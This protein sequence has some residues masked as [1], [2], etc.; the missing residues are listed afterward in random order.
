MVPR[1]AAAFLVWAVT[2][3]ASAQIDLAPVKVEN[4]VEGVRHTALLFRDGAAEISFQPPAGWVASGGGGHLEFQTAI[5]MATVEIASVR[6]PAA[7]GFDDPGVKACDTVAA[8]LVPLDAQEAVWSSRQKNH[9][10]LNRHETYEAILCYN[11]YGFAYKMSVLFVNLESSQ[12][13]FVVC[14]RAASFEKVHEPFRY[15]LFSW[16]WLKSRTPAALT[17]EQ[18]SPRSL[19]EPARQPL[20]K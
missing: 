8:S 17:A 5:P 9:F 14:A 11:R 3:S 13:R 2:F 18:R 10:Y 20:I 1:I 12:L 7:P 15:S 6:L 4:S 19:P 16:Q